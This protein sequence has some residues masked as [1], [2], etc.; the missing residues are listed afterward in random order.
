MAGDYN[1][2]KTLLLMYSL[3]HAGD[4]QSTTP[5]EIGAN[6]CANNFPGTDNLSCVD[7]PDMGVGPCF[8]MEMLCNGQND[9]NGG[10]DEGNV[11]QFNSIECKSAAKSAVR[12]YRLCRLRIRHWRP[13]AKTLCFRISHEVISV[14]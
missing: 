4:S 13:V 6:L 2:L 10:E 3:F 14:D 5:Q 9:C 8:Q 7:Q 1:I 11:N 12:A